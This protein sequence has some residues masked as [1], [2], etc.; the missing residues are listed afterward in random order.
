MQ[1]IWNTEVSSEE[2]VQMQAEI[3]Q[4]LREIELSHERMRRDQEEIE[5]IKARTQSVIAELQFLTNK[6]P[7]R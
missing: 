6:A 5:K 7:V 2:S 4:C 3:A 1:N